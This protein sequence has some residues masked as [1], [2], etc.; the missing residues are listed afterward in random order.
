MQLSLL[1]TSSEITN[2]S[3][4]ILYLYR[5]LLCFK[6]TFH[7]PWSTGQI[8][9][10]ARCHLDHETLTS[11]VNCQELYKMVTFYHMQVFVGSFNI[12]LLSFL[13]HARI[14]TMLSIADF[15]DSF[16]FNLRILNSEQLGLKKLLPTGCETLETLDALFSMSLCL[17]I[18]CLFITYLLTYLSKCVYHIS[19]ITV[20]LVF[21]LLVYI[22]GI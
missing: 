8:S 4:I 6:S 5:G 19:D 3:T 9:L 10:I 14:F 17:V 20:S 22:C 12:E 13:L 7:K 15:V 1:S 2:N 21:K 18:A 11:I 16:Q